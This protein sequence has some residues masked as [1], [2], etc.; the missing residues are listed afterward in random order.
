M[1]P[2]TLLYAPADRPD[3]VRKALAG[4]AD[5]VIIDLEDAVAPSAKDAARSG[6]AELLTGF[7][8]RPVQVRIN[9]IG[10]SWAAADMAAV[11]TLADSVAVRAPKVES[12]DQVAL[13]SES[14]G[15]RPIHALIETPLAIERAFEIAQS[16]VASLGLG[17][18]DLRSALGVQNPD[19]LGWQR[20]RVLNAA[21]AAGLPPVA[22][23]VY[24]HVSDTE[25]LATSCRA[26][27]AAGFVGRAAIHP[28]QL[29]TI[30]AEFLPTSDE[31]DQARRIV[32]GLARAAEAGGGTFVMPDGAFVDIAMVKA[33]QRVMSLQRPRNVA[34]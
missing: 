11:A 14:T 2:L 12:P 26:G 19:D 28:R 31:I 3:L 34:E 27:R 25:G 32:D 10:T 7:M 16:G 29:A 17:E 15:G 6:L 9:A 24:P 22:M 5:V 13:I 21:A 23:S 30:E 4:P 18:A 33:A 8:G 20:A 1:I